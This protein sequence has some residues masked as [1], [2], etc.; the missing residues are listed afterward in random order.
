[1][2]MQNFAQL[3]DALEWLYHKGECKVFIEMTVFEKDGSH[4]YE[5]R[6]CMDD[7]G[8][9]AGY[10]AHWTAQCYERYEEQVTE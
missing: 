4:Q 9:I 7:I 1:M 5:V 3:E 6:S 10:T 2:T 8:N